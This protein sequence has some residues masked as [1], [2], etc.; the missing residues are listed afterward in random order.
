MEKEELLFRAI[1]T[2]LSGY[3][4]DGIT[5]TR[6]NS[7]PEIKY[8]SPADKDESLIEEWTGVTVDVSVRG[9]RMDEGG[10]IEGNYRVE[11]ASFHLNYRRDEGFS[12]ELKNSLSIYPY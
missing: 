10:C 7:L 9:K 3:E 12:V 5:I 11:N 6:V 8:H 4:K 1:N 2:A